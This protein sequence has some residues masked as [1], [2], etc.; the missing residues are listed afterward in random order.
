[1]ESGFGGGINGRLVDV[2]CLFGYVFFGITCSKPLNTNTKA[3]FADATAACGSEGDMMYFPPI[4]M[5]NV[6]FREAFEKLTLGPSHTVWLGVQ[7][8][9]N[10]WIASNGQKVTASMANWADGEPIVAGNC[11]IADASKGSV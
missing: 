7:R 3:T 2:D 11:A 5:Q 9:G 4:K 10:Q 8:S 1:V 6:V